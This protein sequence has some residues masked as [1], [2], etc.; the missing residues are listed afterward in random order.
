V[1]SA[2]VARA[3]LSPAMPV[4]PV[5]AQPG[6]VMA[7]IMTVGVMGRSMLHVAGRMPQ[8]VMMP[9]PHATDRGVPRMLRPSQ[10]ARLAMMRVLAPVMRSRRVAAL[11]VV[12]R[13]GL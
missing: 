5:V 9:G 4:Q 12:M 1:T 7:H 8:M 10:M 2:A 11:M 6:V 3:L 13:R